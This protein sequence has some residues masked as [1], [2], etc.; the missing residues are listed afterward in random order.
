MPTLKNVFTRGKMNLDIDE[1]LLEKGQY[2]TASNIRIA[3][4]SGGN[5]GAIEKSLSNKQ[6]SNL[7]L[8]ENAKTIGGLSDEFEEKLYWLIKSDLGSFII[9]HDVKLKTSSFVLKDIREEN[10]LNFNEDYLV[11]G[12]VLVIDTD[13]NNRF[14]IFTDGN[15]Q[16]KCINIERAKTYRENGFEEEDILLI[17]KPPLSAPEITLDKTASREE[18]NI[19]E[20]FLIFFSRFKYLDGEYSAFSPASKVAFKPTRFN[21]DFSISTNESMVNE[22]N[23]V[24]IEINT[25][26]KLVTEIEVIFK[27]SQHNTLYLVEKYNKTE[28]GWG[29]NVSETV[30]FSNNKI[31]KTISEIQLYRLFDGV[32]LKAKA[33]EI[34]NN[35]IVFGNY[36]ENWNLIDATNI[37]INLKMDL[38]VV[39]LETTLGLPY[40]SNKSNRDYEVGLVYGDDYGRHTTILTSEENTVHIPSNLC[41]KKNNLKLNISQQSNPPKF[42]KWFRVYIKQNR[43][44]Y[45]SIIPTIFYAEQNFVWIKLELSDID[46]IKVGDFVYVKFDSEGISEKAIQTKIIDIEKK[47][48][49][50]L[51]REIEEEESTDLKQQAGTYYKVKP[52]NFRLDLQDLE[53]YEYT[54]YEDN[55]DSR[56]PIGDNFNYIQQPVFYGFGLDD[57]A[58]FGAYTNDADV[59]YSVQ[60]DSIGDNITTF[61]TFSWRKGNGANQKSKQVIDLFEPQELDNGV[62]IF[63]DKNFGHELEDTWKIGAKCMTDDR[64]GTNEDDRGYAIYG[65]NPEN[66]AIYGNASIE[67]IYYEYDDEE[68]LIERTF[69]SSSYYANLEEWFYGDNIFEKIGIDASRIWFRRGNLKR[70]G[71]ED[72][73][74]QI[75]M[76]NDGSG[77]MN[78]IIRSV[79]YEGNRD[80]KPVRIQ[81]TLNI[82]QSQNVIAFETKS[83][84]LNSD[85]FYEIGRT[86]PIVNGFHTSVF[87]GDRNQ[88]SGQELEITLPHYNCFAWGNG[89]ESIKIKDLFNSDSYKFE[90]RPNATIDNFGKNNK[91]ASLTYSQ[92]YSQSLNYNGLNEFNLAQ[93]NSK[94]LDDKF[95]SIQALK[96]FNGNLDTYQ[97]DKVSRVLF[98]KSVLYNQDGSSNIAKSDLIL[99]GV[100]PYSGEFGISTNP[101]SLVS[102]GNSRYWVDKKRGNILRNGQSGIEVISDFGMKDWFRDNLPLSKRILG[103]IDPQNDQYTV[104]LEIEDPVI[105]N[106]VNCENEINKFNVSEEYIYYLQLNRLSGSIVLSYNITSGVAN[107]NAVYNEETKEELNISGSGTL[108]FIRD[109]SSDTDTEVRVTITPVTN[110][111]SY[112]I[113]N[114]CP[115][116]LSSKIIHIVLSSI[117]DYAKNI[118][119]RYLHGNSSFFTEY[120]Y[121]D[122]NLLKL[123]SY[124]GT[125]GLTR[126]PV[127]GETIEIQSYKNSSRTGEFNAEIGDRLG[128]F[129]SNTEIN[130]NDVIENATF[131]EVI[132]INQGSQIQTNKISF[133]YNKVT[134]N[135]IL[136]LI[137]DYSKF[138]NP[139]VT[140]DDSVI[141]CKGES[142][143]I[144]VTDN[145]TDAENDILRPIIVAFPR[146][147]SVVINSNHTIT[148]EHNDSDTQTDSFTYKVTDGTNESNIATVSLNINTA[149]VAGDDVVN[150]TS[151]DN[152]IISVLNNDYDR[153][154]DRL[155]VIINTIPQHGSIV[156]N[157]NNTITYNHNDSDSPIDSFTYYISDGICNSNIATV[158]M[159]IE[160]NEAPVAVDDTVSVYK[161]ENKIISVLNNDYDPDEDDLT[162]F[163]ATN[164]QHGSIVIN[165]NGT[166]TYTHN[167]SNETIDSFTYYVSDGELDSNVATVSMYIEQN[168]APVA[169]DDTVSIYKGESRIIPVLNND[170]DPD[171]D[172]LTV[173]INTNPQHGSIVLNS[174]DTITYTHNGSNETIDSFTYY[175]S[176]GE[177]NS[178]VATVNIGVGIETGS[179]VSA[180]ADTGIYL[181]PILLGTDAGLFIAHFNARNVPDRFQILIDPSGVSNDIEDMEV[182]ADSL[183]VGDHLTLQGEPYEGLENKT[184]V[185][186]DIK[187]YN[188]TNF[189]V[190]KTGQSFNV[191]DSVVAGNLGNR[192]Y[193]EPN[194]P[195]RNGSGGTQIGVQNEVWNGKDNLRDLNYSDGN[196]ALGYQKN[197]STAFRAYIRVYGTGSTV[198]DLIKTELIN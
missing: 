115:L 16:P 194:G 79:G 43:Y 156:L 104:S 27:E 140:I 2:R 28:K 123:K 180:S 108:T 94:D 70:H 89:F 92:P 163:I 74:H 150:L 182:V 107:I 120:I 126:F 192:S 132:T 158:S 36:T 111:V 73:S 34:I 139:P 6:I 80:D 59:R 186:L 187:T 190:T 162:T 177:L 38:S 81:I 93:N 51:E 147:G 198:W 35:I 58:T 15:T 48:R 133:T 172:S 3:N 60:I 82:K 96:E 196:T 20:K 95:G 153:D 25:G 184:Y 169:V 193:T 179:S 66:D 62:S 109:I 149:P 21:F 83:K 9:E 84:D 141:L 181:I 138:N 154:N 44:N 85:V 23:L 13:N 42:A 117:G 102:F 155:T 22:F 166:V 10:V 146:Y 11:T 90:T 173:I 176:D 49:N 112:N 31:Y 127:D 53:V 18:N 131:P 78:M 54:S 86:Y 41:A 47:D 183:F 61:N 105:K 26:S 130:P 77:P 134:D 128:Y 142:L 4:S 145:D 165:S 33:L 125:E 52:K 167:G 195:S 87:E 64:F 175:V 191:E 174:N 106:N 91:I 157:S 151:G 29:N 171:N 178:N 14:L 7:Y 39:P 17:K 188:G 159:Y 129:V 114:A 71:W 161:G 103:G 124:E 32:P 68:E 118:M 100:Q 63:F 88:M 67:F 98:G 12:I 57:L 170:Y 37:P 50:F 55:F 5:V 137:W 75:N 152:T 97:E 65:G 99:D 76:T 143:I 148:Y 164:P 113:S 110:D 46:K 116:G 122:S 8:G 30:Q 19:E 189:E 160:Q 121:F 185:N 136:Y 56:N 1:R 168:E 45:D 24:N 144:P 197:Q 119:H 69:T 40:E 72:R 135:S 101:E